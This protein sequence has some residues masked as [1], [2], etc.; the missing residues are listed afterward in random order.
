MVREERNWWTCERRSQCV[1]VSKSYCRPN[2][3]VDISG[4]YT[5]CRYLLT[6]VLFTM[7]NVDIIG[8]TEV[9]RVEFRLTQ[10]HRGKKQHFA[11]RNVTEGIRMTRASIIPMYFSNP[12]SPRLHH[13]LIGEVTAKLPLHFRTERGVVKHPYTDVQLLLRLFLESGHF[14]SDLA[15]F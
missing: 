7:V 1:C 3:I 8:N 5:G 11:D 15:T 14:L 4:I 6:H 2:T 13:F 10:N 9:K 12:Q